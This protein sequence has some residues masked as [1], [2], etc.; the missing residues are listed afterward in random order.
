MECVSLHRTPNPKLPWLSPSPWGYHRRSLLCEFFWLRGSQQA[1]GTSQ[2]RFYWGQ[3]SSVQGR[4]CQMGVS[5]MEEE[6]STEGVTR[7]GEFPGSEQSKRTVPQRWRCSL[8][9]LEGD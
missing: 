1:G 2:C 4:L 9:P 6:P 3:T 7:G 8:Q 5:E